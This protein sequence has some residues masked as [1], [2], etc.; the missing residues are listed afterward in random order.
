[1]QGTP[2]VRNVL[3]CSGVSVRFGDVQALDDVSIGFAAGKIHALLGQNGAGKTT[4]ARFLTG[5]VRPDSGGLQINGRPVAPGDIAGVRANGLDIVHQRFIFPPGMRVFEALEMCAS[6]K[7]GNAIYSARALATAWGRE[8]RDFGL[9]VEPAC[10]VRELPVETVQS[11]EILRALADDAG[12]LILDEPTA[13][14]T[15][16]SIVDLFRRLRRLRDDGVTLIVILHKLQ[17]VMEI[18]DTVSVLRDGRLV[19][20]PI[21]ADQLS[22]SELSTMMIGSQD[23]PERTTDTES[24]PAREKPRLCIRDLSTRN[25]LV[26]EPELGNINLSVSGSEVL[27]VAGVAG[28]GQRQL[29]SVLCGIAPT[30]EG[31]IELDGAEISDCSVAERREL[32]LRAIPFDRMTEG[33][34]LP[35][36][37]WENATAWRVA[38]FRLGALP[39]VSIGAMKERARK[40]LESLGVRFASVDQPAVSLS[41]GNLQRLILARELAGGASLLVAAQPTRGLDFHATRFVLDCL[42]RL[43]QEG[44]AVVLISS[45][46]DELFEISDR[47][48]VLSGGRVSGEFQPPYRR[49]QIGDSMVGATA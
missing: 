28:N 33:A 4:L 15:P 13:L 19:A 44:S 1:M 38:D 16:G 25:E 5:L 46:L 12:I 2:A 26:G 17:E 20:G 42:V 35:S 31:R 14:L 21:P 18:A 8:M 41:G 6:R 11:L 40:I 10:R 29:A 39:L 22:R 47:I 24:V 43:R 9:D 27:G 32:G 37:L 48:I 3:E 34:S 45:D 30:D 7:R 36:P 49:K 23:F